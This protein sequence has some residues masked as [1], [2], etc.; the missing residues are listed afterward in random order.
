MHLT[1]EWL[2]RIQRW[3]SVLWETCYR[4][5]G[6]L[7][8]SGFTTFDH[9]TADQAS[10]ADFSP[11]PPGTSWGAKWEYGW[12]KTSLV[13]PP[14]AVGQRL[15]FTAVP[16]M[17]DPHPGECLCWANGKEAGSFGWARQFITLSTHALPGTEYHLLME[18]YAGHGKLVVDGGPL[19]FGA[20]RVVDP[21]STQCL[22]GETSFGIWRE[23]IY[24]L[25]VDFSTLLDLYK[26][27]DPLSLR[28]AEIGQ[29]LMQATLIVDPEL[30][31]LEYQKSAQIARQQLR[32]LLACT[33]GSTA[34]TLFAFGHAHIDVAWLWPLAETERKIARTIAN[35]LALIDEYPEYIFLQSQPQLYQMLRNKYPD[36]YERLKDAVSAGRI[37]ADGAMWVEADTNLT[38]GESL[39]RQILVGKHFF[40]GEFGIDSKILW[41]P[42]VFGYSGSLPQILRGCG[43][44]GFATQKI[45]WAY[46]GGEAF[47]Y[48]TFSWEGID[49]TSIPAHIFTDYNSQTR[50]SALLERWN[51]RLQMQGINSMI[52]AFGWGD[53][54]GGPTRDHLEFLR[55]S[56]D[57][58]GVPRTKFASPSEFF[59]NL[60]P[61]AG[62]PRYVGEL[63]FQAHRGTYTS[64]SRVKKANRRLEF[65]LREAEFWGST[66]RILTAHPFTQDSLESAWKTLLLHQFHDILPGSSIQR[67]YQEAEA[68]LTSAIEE[69][70]EHAR[71]AASALLVNSS[72][73][74]STDNGPITIF[75]SLSWPRT[76]IID[77][78][79][80]QAEVT[81]PA[82]GWIT[83]RGDSPAFGMPPID[84]FA[85]GVGA[86][87]SA[88][89]EPGKLE[90]EFLLARF[91]DDGRLVNLVE[92]SSNWEV[93]DGIGN[94]FCLY[95]DVPSAWD[96][97]DIDSIAELQPIDTS[98]PVHLEVLDPGPLVA[99]L[100]LTRSL[101]NSTITQVITLQRGSRRLEFF[102]SIDWQE[103][104]KLL[105]VAFPINIHANEAIHEIQFGHL[106]RPTH[107]S[108]QYDADRFEVCNHKW[109][110]LADDQ[111]GAAILNDSKY[112]LSVDRSTIKLTL[113]K[114]A[115][116]PDPHADRGRQSFTYAI[117]P[118]V[119]ALAQ[120]R[121]VQEAYELNIPP[122]ILNGTAKEGSIFQISASNIILD[123]MKPAEDRSPDLILRLYESVHAATHCILTTSFPV[124]SATQTN[125]LEEDIKPLHIHQNKVE[126][127]F[128]PFE[129]KT[130][131]LKLVDNDLTLSGNTA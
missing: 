121:V 51:T 84:G 12:F 130:I 111:H 16:A 85:F 115:I 118:W 31:D 14:D 39:I 46:H 60:P 94:L 131:R 43:C 49:G 37:I 45:T 125:M 81:I 62:L 9:L 129:I 107:R 98:E 17:Q 47:P 63:Y 5:L 7:T 54:G 32:P 59:A 6:E 4:P 48:N 56:T 70:E 100:G 13:V 92:K 128:R 71:Q 119:G 117:Y 44:T 57:L 42:D 19:P 96:A 114:S 10:H 106:R 58:E 53:G 61:H 33:N 64:Q 67:V 30:P 86:T 21:P 124:Q 65:A 73:L 78:H 75:N 127:T 82:C 79:N 28:V 50:P 2:H 38:S 3:E 88:R 69:A 74:G 66:A 34:P 97:W 113:L 18:A 99:Q 55:R 93:M 120:S 90:N 25:A 23:D 15:V 80:E 87:S 126:L 41:L 22:V 91:D 35:Q 29:G 1:K 72:E 116:A 68:V 109:T 104:H 101:S 36:L 108:R 122:L 112:G 11:M 52:L 8:L 24:Q 27:L 83:I 110:A 95:K 123:T 103:Q 105:K 76:T 77:H 40:Q 20:E 102:T 26:G 89:A